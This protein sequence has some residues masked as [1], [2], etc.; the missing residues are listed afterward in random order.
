MDIIPLSPELNTLLSYTHLPKG[1]SICAWVGDQRSGVVRVLKSP[2]WPQY[3]HLLVSSY[4]GV[5]FTING[6]DVVLIRDKDVMCCFFPA[7][8]GLLDAARTSRP[9]GAVCPVK[10]PTPADPEQD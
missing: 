5:D 3:A 7:A 6:V 8:T 1:R 2:S 4:S 10:L 9:S